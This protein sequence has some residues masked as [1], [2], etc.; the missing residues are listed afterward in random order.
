MKLN[1]F[2]GHL[3]CFCLKF[4]VKFQLNTVAW[5]CMTH[6]LWKS[7]LFL[8][9]RN[10]FAASSIHMGNICLRCESR[11]DLMLKTISHERKKQNWGNFH[12][13]SRQ[14]KK[15]ETTIWN[16]CVIHACDVLFLNTFSH[17]WNIIFKLNCNYNWWAGK[18]VHNYHINLTSV[19]TQKNNRLTFK[20][21]LNWKKIS[22]TTKKLR[23]FDFN[24][25]SHKIRSSKLKCKMQIDEITQISLWIGKKV[26]LNCTLTHFWIK[27]LSTLM[28]KKK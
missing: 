4:E 19:L 28:W 24:E 26:P 12:L 8:C 15:N 21:S 16:I 2:Y 7:E 20:L 25:N 5:K 14:E 3:N 23:K 27:T 10:K 11:L 18:I 9:L 6:L 22:T 17:R 13:F 1:Y